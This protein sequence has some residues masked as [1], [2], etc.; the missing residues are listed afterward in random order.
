MGARHSNSSRCNSRG[1]KPTT[2]VPKEQ[3]RQHLS[4]DN[5]RPCIDRTVG[6]TVQCVKTV[7]ATEVIHLIAKERNKHNT[8]DTSKPGGLTKASIECENVN[9]T[10][11]KSQIGHWYA[12][13]GQVIG[14]D[15]QDAT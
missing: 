11:L 13:T 4:K 8:N 15:A 5:H 2:T 7:R 12:E 10:I 1:K 9:L 6:N 3:G 14:V